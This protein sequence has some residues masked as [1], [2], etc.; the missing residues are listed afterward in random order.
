MSTA[1]M[2][3]S[4]ADTLCPYLS[5]RQS[6]IHPFP[7]EMKPLP[8]RLRKGTSALKHQSIYL[9]T[10]HPSLLPFLPQVTEKGGIH[11]RL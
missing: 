3:E 11:P 2:N 7:L 10:H 5:D 9:G 1:R 8:L 4:F 6:I